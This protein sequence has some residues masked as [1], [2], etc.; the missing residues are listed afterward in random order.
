MNITAGKNHSRDLSRRLFEDP[1]NKWVERCS[2]FNDTARTHT[3]DGKFDKKYIKLT[4]YY[5]PISSS[6]EGIQKAAQT[7]ND[8]CTGSINISCDELG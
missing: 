5:V 1:F 3:E 4:D 2:A 8:M 6:I 7:V